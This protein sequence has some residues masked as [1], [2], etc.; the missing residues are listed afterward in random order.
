[1]SQPAANHTL[2]KES[3]ISQKKPNFKLSLELALK[4]RF[5]SGYELHPFTLRSL[6]W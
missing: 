6:S 5:V 3:R 2:Y 1:M 4:N